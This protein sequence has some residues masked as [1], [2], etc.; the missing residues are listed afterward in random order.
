MITNSTL[1][2]SRPPRRS[3]KKK[4]GMGERRIE[5]ARLL[6]QH[7]ESVPVAAEVLDLA[8]RELE[9]R[10]KL[11]VLEE[12]VRVAKAR[13]VQILPLALLGEDSLDALDEPDLF[14]NPDL[15][16][17]SRDRDAV[18]LADFLGAD[19]SLVGGEE[20]FRAVFVRQKLGCL[21]GGQE[22]RGPLEFAFIVRRSGVISTVTALLFDVADAF[23]G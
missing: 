17:A 14:Q 6:L 8:G 7:V 10:A 4:E 21:E 15:P 23:L 18:S 12:D 5:T 2:H 9:P 22:F 20:D 11:A 3:R 1:A 13:G 16:V 19:L